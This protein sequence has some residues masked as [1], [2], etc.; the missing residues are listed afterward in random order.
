MIDNVE[1]SVVFNLTSI[2]LNI[3]S[4]NHTYNDQE[5]NLAVSTQWKI[6]CL[7]M[8][9]NKIIELFGED[10][11]NENAIY[12]QNDDVIYTE[13]EYFTSASQ[14]PKIETN[15]RQSQKPYQRRI[16]NFFKAGDKNSPK[17]CYLRIC[18]LWKKK[19]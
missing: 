5:R 19:I 15:T 10:T 13:L 7:K 1:C 16:H 17:T 8:N 12:F 18:V 14:Q 6:N 9:N 3:C 2:I 4:M 11:T